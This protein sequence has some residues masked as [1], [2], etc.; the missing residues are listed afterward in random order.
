VPDHATYQAAGVDT[1]GEETALGLVLGHLERTLAF[2]RGRLGGVKLPN[3]FFANVL[4]LGNGRGLAISTDGVG[5]KVMIAQELGKYDTIGIDCVAMNAN[6]V[7]CVGA[8]PLSMVDYLAVEVLDPAVVGEIARGLAVG[9]ERANISIPGGEMA[10]LPESVR[11]SASGLG[12]DLVGT[13]VGDVALDR[14]IVGD[15]IV[16]G[17]AI[18]GLRSTGIHSNGLTL[19][20]RVLF[21]DG[22]FSANTYSEDLAAKVGEV[23]LEP[24]RIYVREV[25][26]MLRD[27]LQIK[28]LVH[29]TSDG[30]LNLARIRRP[31]G[32]VLERLPAPQPIF[33]LIQESGGVSDA[34]MFK[35]YNMGT[36]F[37]IVVAQADVDNARAIAGRYGV[38]SDV[39]GHTV[40]DPRQ[41][42]WLEPK[43]LVGE[44][45]QFAAS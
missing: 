20:R 11:G 30:F 13:C 9:A 45:K 41:R 34:E 44:D 27:G 6:D 25:L 39:L 26:E 8:E 28:A 14:L 31:I 15:G 17:D 18:V 7:L 23:L 40:D 29:V 35:T 42:V 2:R 36:G 32:Y 22:R 19:A 4:D 10:Q 24:T 43:R 12:F 33:A 5:S 37:C 38:E 3:G 16:P 1:A 21:G